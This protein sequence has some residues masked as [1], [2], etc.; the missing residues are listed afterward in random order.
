MEPQKKKQKQGKQRITLS[1]RF[2]TEIQEFGSKYNVPTPALEMSRTPVNFPT[3]KIPR[4][5]ISITNGDQHKVLRSEQPGIRDYLK[6]S[7]LFWCDHGGN[8]GFSYQLNGL[9]LLPWNDFVNRERRKV[10]HAMVETSQPV[11]VIVNYLHSQVNGSMNKY[12]YP[13]INYT[14]VV[15]A[16]FGNG[17]FG[18]TLLSHILKRAKGTQVY[19]PSLLFRTSHTYWCNGEE[20]ESR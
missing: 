9:C 15:L 12:I 8:P 20:K 17:R 2:L 3:E 1:H 14:N 16:F 13:V 5:T 7:V 18:E 4:W 10:F 6:A 11:H 19:N